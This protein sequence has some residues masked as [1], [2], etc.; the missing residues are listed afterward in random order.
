MI[1]GGSFLLLFS[2]LLILSI[3]QYVFLK[4]SFRKNPPDFPLPSTCISGEN[5]LVNLE[6]FIPLLFP[7]FRCIWKTELQWVDGGRFLS[8]NCG[9]SRGSRMYDVFFENTH[10][11]VYRGPSGTLVLEDLFGFTKFPLFTGGPVVLHIYPGVQT[12]GFTKER[13]ITGGETATVERNRIRTDELLEVR[14]YYPGDDA[15]RI[16]WKMFAASGELF[17]RIGEEVPPPTGEV[18]IVLNSFSPALSSLRDSSDLTDTLISSYITFIY[19]FVEKGCIVRVL[20]P[21]MRD[22]IEFNPRKPDHLFKILSDVTPA[23]KLVKIPERDFLYVLS[24]P[25]SEYLRELAV[26]GTGEVKVFIKALPEIQVNSYYRKLLF[27]DSTQ[28]GLSLGEYFTYR[29]LEKAVEEDV[30]N[31]N[32][33]G[34]GK[35]HC[36]IL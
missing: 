19:S 24:H 21:G 32:R 27:R 2:I 8:S 16:N 23:D 28:K 12:D 34:K 7:G 17:L 35:I 30:S 3:L 25:L 15:R 5:F 26:K 1:W 9:L 10:R 13:I 11:G 36:E 14:K 4:K 29:E 33:S 6:V 31:L 22:F 20:A 18:A